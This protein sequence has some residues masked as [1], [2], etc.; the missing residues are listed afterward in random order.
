[1]TTKLLPIATVALCAC[2]LPSMLDGQ[3]VVASAGSHELTLA[4]PGEP[5]QLVSV[6]FLKP[7]VARGRLD[8]LDAAAA[9][10]SDVEGAFGTLP[11]HTECILLV[12][13][14][15]AAGV[16]FRIQQPAGNWSD[17]PS[18]VS[19]DPSHAS[20]A[21]ALLSGGEAFSVHPMFRLD[22]IVPGD[23]SVLP[24]GPTDVQAGQ[25]HIH[26]PASGGFTKYWLSDGSLT[27]GVPGWTMAEAG[28]L[29]TGVPV[30]LEPGLSFYIWHPA[31]VLAKSVRIAGEVLDS[32]LVKDVAPGFNFLGIEFNLTRLDAGGFP[33]FALRDLGLAESGFRAVEEAESA[34]F[35]HWLTGGPQ[36]M[37]SKLW[38]KESAGGPVWTD[39][40]NP[41][42]PRDATEFTP[43]QGIILWSGGVEGFLWRD[44]IP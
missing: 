20:G 13:D 11:A 3:V 8:G 44:G 31:P 17:N 39:A 6:P 4:K 2:L 36:P 33:S 1:M 19:L 15:P 18:E 21:F 32:P 35:L 12:R 25:V 40:D 10:V 42:L 43:G 41:A 24:T 29:V 22:E 14:G 5:Y 7:A 28:Q 26:D 34:D 37:V 9:S 38:L 16:W 30:W 27:D 23:G